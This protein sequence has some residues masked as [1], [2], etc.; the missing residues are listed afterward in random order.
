MRLLLTFLRAYPRRTSLLLLCLIAGGL[1]E[2]IGLSG[3]LPFLGRAASGEAAQNP[4]EIERRITALVRALGFEPTMGAF[5]VVIIGG[6]VLKAILTL[7]ANRQA[8]YCV[9]HVATDLRLELL[10]ALLGSRWQYYVGQRIGTFANAFA[11][12]AQR[13]A[14]SYLR[15]TTILSL[16]VQ[17]VVYFTVAVLVSWQAAVLAV[18]AGLVMAVLLHQLVR[19]SKRAGRKQTGLMKDIV[20]RLTDVLQSIKPL[21]AMGREQLV[22]PLLDHD[23]HRLDEVLRKKVLSR[24]AFKSLQD[25]TIFVFLAVGVYAAATMADIALPSVIMLALLSERIIS[26]SGKIQ[27]E[28]QEMV[29]DE[30]AYWSIRATIDEIEASREVLGG[31]LEP[32]LERAVTLHGVHFGYAAEPVLRGVDLT[33]PAGE[34]TA[35]VGASGA[36]KTT[37]ADL[38]VGLIAPQAGE[39]RIDD[40]PLGRIDTAR[41]RAA[42]GYVPQDTLLLH[43]SIR[44]N[45]TLGDPDI[46]DAMVG[47]AVAAAGLQEVVSALPQGLD[48]EVGE[49]G[50][51]LSGGQRQRIALARAL[52]RKPALLILDEATTALDPA[53]E[54]AICETLRGLRG[55]VTMLAICHQGAIIAMAD[56][57]YRIETGVARAER[58]NGAEPMA[59]RAGGQGGFV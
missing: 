17:S 8:G 11:T 26:G 24:T 16:V 53:T 22:G 13:A 47:A 36:G 38:I 46:D 33:I 45:V 9:A 34:L 28:Y 52:V 32:R 54:A 55:A 12:E 51:R 37:I 5:L 42:I 59:R 57:V 20:A 4:T 19:M 18:G 29:L 40:V 50:L 7:I 58:P 48:T 21:K 27:R 49:R 15:A 10:R 31:V 35:L 43:D 3:L 44:V 39:L 30:S 14:E 41:W 6:V 1:A 56:R 25:P 2:G 23:I